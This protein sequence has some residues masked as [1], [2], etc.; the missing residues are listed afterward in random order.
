[1]LLT[2]GKVAINNCCLPQFTRKC[3]ISTTFHLF[4]RRP[5][6]KYDVLLVGYLLQAIGQD[7]QYSTSKFTW[8]SISIE[9]VH[10]GYWT[11]EKNSSIVKMWNSKL[12][13]VTHSTEIL[14]GE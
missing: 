6:D 12:V 7:I 2:K 14:Q 8:D 1:M 13:C 4:E 9:M 11:K 10:S 5:N 3:H